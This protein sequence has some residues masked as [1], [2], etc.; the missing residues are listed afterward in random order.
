MG[1]PNKIWFRKDI[2]WWMVTL[3][4]V[5]TRL[6]EGKHNKK[7]AEDKFHELCLQRS[8]APESS[9]ARVADI[10]EAFLAWAK[11][12]RSDE[13]NRNY[14]W[15]GQK[16][17]E[18]VGYLQL[19]EL[20]PIHVTRFVDKHGWKDTTERNARRSVYRA[21]SWAKEEGVIAE[22]PL[23]GMKCPK[24]RTR[25]RALTSGEYVLLMRKSQRDF[26]RLLFSLRQT[27]CRPKEARTLQWDQVKEDRWVLGK[28][29]T[30]HKV[31]KPRVIFLSKPMQRLMRTLRSRSESDY[32]FL[33]SRGE[34]VDQRRTHRQVFCDFGN[35]Q[36]RAH[37]ASFAIP[38]RYASSSGAGG[39]VFFA[40]LRPPSCRASH[41]CFLHKRTDCPSF[42][43][44][45]TSVV[46]GQ[47]RHLPCCLS[48]TWYIFV[49]PV[50]VD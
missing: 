12:H 34:P 30:Q 8:R 39:V 48:V 19:S 3:G 17:S 6:A 36:E 13:T 14:I 27:G 33:N 28:H 20:K 10:I 24:A 4:G 7:A 46:P 32:V 21:F 50:N 35:R 40:A 25:E 18:H 29:K 37:A 38:W 9:S 15:Y 41:K 26:K 31:G 47:S 1:R 22:N 2:G 45:T 43:S 11:I 16:F 23:R 42:L 5:K 44:S 49:L